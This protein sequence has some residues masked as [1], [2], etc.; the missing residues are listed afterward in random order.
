MSREQNGLQTLQEGFSNYIG[1]QAG[2]AE[3]KVR[4][5]LHTQAD[6]DLKTGTSSPATY[7]ELLV[8]GI[9]RVD[10]IRRLPD[11]IA[12]HLHQIGNLLDE[13]GIGIPNLED[14]LPGLT[15][16]GTILPTPD[17]AM[18]KE[19]QEAIR[20]Q[21]R[22]MIRS[23]LGNVDTFGLT[24]RELA[25]PATRIDLNNRV[26]NRLT[27]EGILNVRAILMTNF[28]DIGRIRNFG[29]VA[30]MELLS[31]L[32]AHDIVP[33]KPRPA[34][35][36]KPTSQLKLNA[37]SKEEWVEARALDDKFKLISKFGNPDNFN[38]SSE[39][40]DAPLSLSGLYDYQKD[41]LPSSLITVRDLVSSQRSEH[42]YLQFIV[43]IDVIRKQF[44]HPLQL[45]EDT[46]QLLTPGAEN[47]LKVRILTPEEARKYG[48]FR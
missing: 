17:E 12:A 5:A 4:E 21:R 35:Q 31:T 16:P 18:S 41:Q 37:L 23:N 43:L 7:Q 15:R 32:E 40:L 26:I 28:E 10:S 33:G 19:Q 20:E 46:E 3:E 22:E 27:N 9:Q 42:S 39:Q 34:D 1:K 11:L 30:G 45:R 47:M 48:P 13:A 36:T 44:G 25:F 6:L 14:I 8:S 29:S 24:E 38:L 2:L